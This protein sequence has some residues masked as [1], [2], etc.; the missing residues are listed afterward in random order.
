ML[1]QP[2][3]GGFNDTFE[4]FAVEI[5]YPVG[6]LFQGVILMGWRLWLMM[7]PSAAAQQ[8]QGLYKEDDAAV[9]GVRLHSGKCLCGTV[10]GVIVAATCGQR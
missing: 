10:S 8:R 5:L 4:P 2:P 6:A 1:H 3:G 9:Q 7:N